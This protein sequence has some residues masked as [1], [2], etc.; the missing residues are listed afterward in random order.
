MTL[1]FI[2]TN[3]FSVISQSTQQQIILEVVVLSFSYQVTVGVN[4]IFHDFKEAVDST[5][6]KI[7][8]SLVGSLYLIALIGRLWGFLNLVYILI[9]A[10]HIVFFYNYGD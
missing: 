8:L 6:L 3:Y 2:K 10:P 9:V 7:Y 5:N 1:W 4:T